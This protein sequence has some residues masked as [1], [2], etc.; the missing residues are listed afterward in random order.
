ME[1]EWGGTGREGGNES[2]G[3]GG[4]REGEAFRLE[5]FSIYTPGQIV[6]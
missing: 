6:T 5:N 3:R 1:R 2:D 4:E